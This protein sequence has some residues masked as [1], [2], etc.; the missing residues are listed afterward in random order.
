MLGFL[1]KL[2]LHPESV[3]TEDAVPL[4]AAGISDQASKDAI[5]VCTLFNIIDRLTDAL[6]FAIPSPEHFTNSA[7]SSATYSYVILSE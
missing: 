1:E 2:T 7:N 3:G 5:T 4:Q 6:S